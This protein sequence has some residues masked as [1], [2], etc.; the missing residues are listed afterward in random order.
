MTFRM[1]PPPKAATPQP[2]S[3]SP[4]TTTRVEI[5]GIRLTLD[6]VFAVVWKVVLAIVMT[7]LLPVAVL[8]GVGVVLSQVLG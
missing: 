2:A 7:L 1:D 4:P 8:I 3:Y 5:V 6:Q